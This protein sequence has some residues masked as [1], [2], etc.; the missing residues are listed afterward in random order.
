MKYQGKKCIHNKITFTWWHG[1]V[2]NS[3][4]EETIL[5]TYKGS[6]GNSSHKS[7]GILLVQLCTQQ[8][9]HIAMQRK[10]ALTH[11]HFLPQPWVQPDEIRVR[12]LPGAGA[13]VMYTGESDEFRCFHLQVLGSKEFHNHIW[14]CRYTQMCIRDSHRTNTRKRRS[15]PKS[16]MDPQHL[17]EGSFPKDEKSVYESFLCKHCLL[18]TSLVTLKIKIF[19]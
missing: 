17:A 3:D 14:I 6:S 4:G 11:L 8:F 10:S 2:N 5:L 19:I 15:A 1:K 9:L 16:L 18:Y 13:C 12:I 7:M